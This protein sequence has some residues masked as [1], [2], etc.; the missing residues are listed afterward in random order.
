MTR[1]R[2]HQFFMLIFCVS[3]FAI[4]TSCEGPAGKD[5]V[6][7]INGD[8]GADGTP[9]VAGN[10]V[11][12]ECHNLDKKERVTL[13]YHTSGHAAGE[14]VAYAGNRNDCAMCHSDQGFRETRYTGADTMFASLNGAAQP[15]QCIT[16]HSFHES[17]DFEN[18]HNYALRTNDAVA[19]LMYRADD[20]EAESVMLDLGD[21]SN[22]C[23][24]CHQPRTVSPK[25]DNEG[26]AHISSS[27]YDGPHRGPQ[28]TSLAGF[29]A[30][31]IGTGWPDPGTGS[32]HATDASCITC[33]MPS[34]DHSWTP[35]LDACNTTACHGS[36][37]PLSTYSENLRQTTFR[38]D[39]ELLKSKLQTA[40]LLDEEGHAVKGTFGVDSVGAVY[41][42][43]WLVA[44]RS[45][46]VHNF[47][48]TERMITSSLAV[49]D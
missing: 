35:S 19:L 30:Y 1:Q 32:K 10:A 34:A 21:D 3:I 39:L 42:Y 9:G 15:I 27:H 22:L 44:D 6:D 43:K 33:H 49:F 29:G 28:S 41:N 17:L 36:M 24:N 14:A 25:A 11:C 40:G 7:G 37:T 47:T 20:P 26:N 13:E 46:G 8:N 45:S 16:C 12:M 5:G 31:E 18:E 48:Y 4:A 38:S 2:K 23:A